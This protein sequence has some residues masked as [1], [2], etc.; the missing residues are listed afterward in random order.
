VIELLPYYIKTAVMAK[1]SLNIFHREKA[2][3]LE[4]GWK[5]FCYKCFDEV[6]AGA[7][8]LN[9]TV[10]GYVSRSLRGRTV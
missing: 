10:G 3:L 2:S 8:P 1:S 6:H 7:C 5:R 4:V 9:N